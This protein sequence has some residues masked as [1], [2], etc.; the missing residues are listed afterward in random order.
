MQG[1]EAAFLLWIGEA[2]RSIIAA[3]EAEGADLVIVGNSWLAEIWRKYS[4][5][6]LAF[7]LPEILPASAKISLL[8][9]TFWQCGHFMNQDYNRTCSSGKTENV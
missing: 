5:P 1:V 4:G 7:F 9:M 6:R 8:G 2:G 3:A